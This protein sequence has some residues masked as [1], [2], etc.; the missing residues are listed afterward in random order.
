MQERCRWHEKAVGR[1]QRPAAH[2]QG[3][4]SVSAEDEAHAVRHI[5]ARGLG[6]RHERDQVPRMPQIILAEVRDIGPAGHRKR[7]VVRGRLA[8]GVRGEIQEAHA[9]IGGGLDDRFG[10]RARVAT[11]QNL[12]RNVSLRERRRQR[13]PQG[14]GPAEGRDDD[15]YDRRS[16][17][18]PGGRGIAAH[19]RRA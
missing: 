7:R 6:R 1:W 3:A 15:R 19:P 8:A 11:D 18:P 13:E 9:R 4:G 14:L 10:K 17:N 5:G 16:H 12:D 2:G